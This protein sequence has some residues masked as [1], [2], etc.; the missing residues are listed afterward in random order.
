MMLGAVAKRL[1][2]TEGQ[3]YTMATG[4]AVAAWLGLAGRAPAPANALPQPLPQVQPS[5]TPTSSVV[6]VPTA[7]VPT[8]TAV[9]LPPTSGSPPPGVVPPAGFTPQP[10]SEPTFAQRPV[11]ARIGSPGAPGGLAV[12][13]DGQLYVGTDNGTARGVPGASKLF[14]YDGRT[15]ALRTQTVISGQPRGHA[16]GLG[17]LAAGPTAVYAVDID[18]SRV[19]RIDR[20]TH[21]QTLAT[22]VPD[23][24]PCLV[25]PGANPCEPGALDHAPTLTALALDDSGALFIADSGQATIWRLPAGGHAV[26]PWYQSMDFATGD[27]PAGLVL[28]SAGAVLVTVGTSLDA[29]NPSMGGLYSI[30]R[31]ADGGPGAR[32]LLASFT[33]S[34]KPGPLALDT[35]GVVYVILRGTGS[36]V[37]VDSGTSTRLTTASSPIPLDDPS[38]LAVAGDRLLIANRGTNNNASHWAVLSFPLPAQS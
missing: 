38:A 19:L 27:G 16:D 7:P 34:E 8:L 1:G 9:P 35:S 5:A 14:Q 6:V 13:S 20:V 3:L 11:L 17:A 30:A 36:I 25:T 31:G 29:G 21:S 28:D 37:S 33:P 2:C 32:T 24:K 26:S 10:T 15:G 23:L 18:A 4:L 12:T 22:A